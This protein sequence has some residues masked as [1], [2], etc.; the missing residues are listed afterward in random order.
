MVA[1]VVPWNLKPLKVTEP[2]TVSTS[3]ASQPL[4]P[5]SSWDW[6]KTLF[7][8]KIGALTM[9]ITPEGSVKIKRLNSPSSNTAA[10]PE[11]ERSR[12]HSAA[13]LG[14]STL[15]SPSLSLYPTTVNITGPVWGPQNSRIK[16]SKAFRKILPV[17]FSTLSIHWFFM[18]SKCS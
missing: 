1:T 11:W 3:T 16:R 17:I 14:P 8:E 7:K 2:L 9:N 18:V 13:W 6:A 5:N 4:K 10:K 15:L 12:H